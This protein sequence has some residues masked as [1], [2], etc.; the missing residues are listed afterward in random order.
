MDITSTHP[1]Y[2]L[3]RQLMFHKLLK[4]LTAV[5][6]VLQP[7]CQPSDDG[8]CKGHT[9]WCPR[10]IAKLV[11]IIT[12]ISLRFIDV[13]RISRTSWAYN[14]FINIYKMFIGYIELI[15]NFTSGDSP[16]GS[17]ASRTILA[18]IPRK[19][20]PS[21]CRRCLHQQQ[22]TSPASDRHLPGGQ[23]C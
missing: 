22:W 6:L 23:K 8:G 9:S 4:D 19:N 12:P 20:P 14:Q 11:Q 13:Y 3:A 21:P 5:D 2:C 1:K 18:T 15:I 7:S 10:S 16:L 17:M